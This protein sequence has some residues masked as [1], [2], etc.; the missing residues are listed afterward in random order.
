MRK[1]VDQFQVMAPVFPDSA[2]VP[3]WLQHAPY[4]TEF[5][6]ALGDVFL[7]GFRV[8]DHAPIL[9]PLAESNAAT[10]ILSARLRAPVGQ[11]RPF[12]F[13]YQRSPADTGCPVPTC[14]TF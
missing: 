5:L 7:A 13:P 4:R 11:A 3:G 10:L 2:S 14:V 8:L 6:R 12:R 9:E 1:W